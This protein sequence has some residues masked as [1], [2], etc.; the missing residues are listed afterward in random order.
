VIPE[1]LKNIAGSV[2]RWALTALAAFLVRKGVIEGGSAEA[3]VA[4]AGVGL[5][6]LTWSL[7]LKYKDRLH[8]L[9]A[10]SMPV[11]STEEDVKTAAKQGNGS[12]S[13]WSVLLLVSILPAAFGLSACGDKENKDTLNGIAKSLHRVAN[14]T[15][16]ADEV[17]HRFFVDGV[18]DNEQAEYITV[19][20]RDI[21]TSAADF[22]RRAKTYETFDGQA[23]ADILQ[24]AGDTRDFINA[25][26]ADGTAR[27]KNPEARENWRA[28][29]NAAYDAFASIVL[30]VRTAKSQPTPTP[31]PPEF[32]FAN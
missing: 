1:L 16:R 8:F 24:L 10:L 4:G 20:L 11:G 30:L 19:V 12:T 18:I 23:K 22:E 31:L 9:T 28:I 3:I 21:N 5:A 6:S 27:I 13:V 32:A 7:W 25:R 26:L 2:T 17:T 14:A 29:A 15:A